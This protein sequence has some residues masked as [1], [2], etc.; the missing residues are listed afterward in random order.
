MKFDKSKLTI[1]IAIAVLFCAFAILVLATPRNPQAIFRVIDASGHPIAGATIKPNALRTKAGPYVSGCYGWMSESNHVPNPPVTTDKNG[2]AIVPYPK[3]VIEKLETGTLCL[4]VSHPDYVAQSPERVVADNLP[5]GAPW[6]QRLAEIWQRVRFR[7]LVSR[8][9]PIVLE[10]GGVLKI[11]VTNLPSAKTGRTFAQISGSTEISWSE[12]QPGTLLS[13]QIAPGKHLARI[14]YISPDGNWFTKS[15]DINA[16]KNKT[17]TVSLGLIHG[18]TVR[19]QLDK[20]VPRPVKHGRVVAQ[21]WPPG[22]KAEDD[23]PTWHAWSPVAENGTF[24]IPSLPEGA[25]E[26]VAL[27][28]GYLSTNGPGK[29]NMRYP[30]KHTL[31]TNDLDITVGMEPTATLEVVLHDN[32]DKPVANAN[33]V[34]WPNV[35]YGEWEATIFCGDTYNTGELLIS[36][37]KNLFWNIYGKWRDFQATTDTTGK[38]ILSNLP[39]TT[40]GLDI[41]H[42]RF[43]P[44]VWKDTIGRKT[45]T[46]VLKL[47]TA[48]TN[49]L[50]LNLVPKSQAEITHY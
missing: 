15:I 37:N 18:V 4:D 44:P 43:S 50:T 2:T 13:S 41:Q 7:T 8:P 48:E 17:N 47:T 11:V 3:Y 25:F 32:E 23:P 46:I 35:R 21:V 24:T 30:Q 14:A 42:E 40:D 29:F 34:T 5:A 49:H 26:I 20:T 6:K 12:P 31:T 45:R 36:T 16:K 22:A 33:V 1:P 19:G 10:K 27:C 28:D 9:K 38:A 39:P